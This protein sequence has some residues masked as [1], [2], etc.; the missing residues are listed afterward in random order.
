MRDPLASLPTFGTPQSQ[1]L[2]GREGDQ[3]RNAAG[4]YVFTLDVWRRLEDF[5]ILGTAGGT[6]YVDATALT[7]DNAGVVRDAIALDGP[8]AV[9]VAEEVSTARPP[10]APSNR[11]A[12]FVIAAAFAWGDHAA[13]QA[14]KSALPRVA[15]TTD[16]LATW[17]G[18]YKELGGASS[19]RVGKLRPRTFRSLRTA[20]AYP[21]VHED[22]EDLAYRACK[23]MQRRTP[24]SEEFHLRD[25]MRMAHPVASTPQRA[26]LFGWIAGNVTDD[27]ARELV[28]RVDDFL[29][30][31]A[32]GSARE[33]RR[34]ISQRNF[35]WEFLPDRW[36]TEP[37]VWD[38]LIDTIGVTALLRNLGR[39]TRLGTLTPLGDATRR[40]SARLTDADS[41]AAARVHPM[42]AYLVLAA[43][44]AG[45]TPARPGKEPQHWVPVTAVCDALEEAWE[46]SYGHTQPSGRRLLIAVDASSSMT[47]EQVLA[48]GTPVG[49]TYQVANTLA[50]IMLRIERGNAHVIEVTTQMVPSSLTARTSLTEIQRWRPFGGGTD[51]AVPF[52]WATAEHVEADGV[53]VLTDN[54]TWA[55]EKHASQALTEYRR[56]VS[57]AA[58]LVVASLNA[59]G[60]SIGDPRDP[61][62]VNVAGLDASLPTLVTEFMRP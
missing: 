58:R 18:Y 12:L 7:V 25:V 13:R 6:F 10:R 17:F 22:V 34:V 51:L 28:R 60:T 40:V 46:L 38:A 48:S 9:A 37:T 16:H 55:G 39:M 47:W 35:P 15:R 26:A 1:P 20:L 24:Q 49:T 62:V 61:G 32:V 56:R 33:A 27:Q 4:G 43:Y 57:P 42:T 14:A 5:V 45:Q 53:L 19:G 23:A 54:E 36:L 3:V 59:T 2:P 30:A 44:R 41:L 50:A 21:F 29:T 8:R 31:Q 11:G 52:A